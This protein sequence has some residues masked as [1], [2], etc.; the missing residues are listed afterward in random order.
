IR[1]GVREGFHGA[2]GVDN[3]PKSRVA[4]RKEVAAE[5]AGMRIL[6]VQPSEL[7]WPR[8]PGWS[9]DKDSVE[10][11]EDRGVETDPQRDGQH[12]RR[13]EPWGSCQT[14]KRVCR[15]LSHAIEP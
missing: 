3:G 1:R 4:E 8:N 10:H 2:E 7:V 14:A 5:I 15:V 13:R 6:D 12:D 11:R 9:S